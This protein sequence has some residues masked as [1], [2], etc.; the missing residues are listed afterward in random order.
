MA[1]R[2][3]TATFVSYG[4]ATPAHSTTWLDPELLLTYDPDIAQ[5]SYRTRGTLDAAT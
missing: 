3:L 2:R 4:S 5:A 1:A